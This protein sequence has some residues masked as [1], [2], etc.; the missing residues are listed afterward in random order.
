MRTT[1]SLSITLPIEMAEMV[2][3]KVASGEYASESEVI[4]DGLRTL[5]ARDSVVERWLR[6][7]VAPAYDAHKADPTRAVPLADGMANVRA[8]IAKA[9]SRS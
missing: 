3:A 1:Q 4:R 9:K 8:H 5:A 6:E 2:K 7:E